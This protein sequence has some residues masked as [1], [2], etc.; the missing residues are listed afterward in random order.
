MA[1]KIKKTRKQKTEETI[2][3]MKETRA[4]DSA[5]LREVIIAKKNWTEKEI[6]RGK[7]QQRNI[8]VTINKLEGVLAF[9]DDMLAPVEKIKK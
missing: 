9:I 1:K 2:K 3:R 5:H 4:I 7:Q 8:Q 6:L